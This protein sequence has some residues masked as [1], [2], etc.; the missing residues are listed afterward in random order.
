MI[1]FRFRFPGA[2]GIGAALCRRLAELNGKVVVADLNEA[3]AWTWHGSTTRPQ[4]AARAVAEP[5]QGLAVRCD[6]AREMD[7]RRLIAIAEALGPIEVFVGNAG[8]PSNGGYEARSPYI[9]AIHVK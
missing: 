6:V 8:I 3:T 4:E 9:G 2:S 5:L 7:V 1:R